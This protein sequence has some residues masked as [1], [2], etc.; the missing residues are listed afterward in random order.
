[1]YPCLHDSFECYARTCAR[2]L[3]HTHL[4]SQV[5]RRSEA[6][7]GLIDQCRLLLDTA[8]MWDGFKRSLDLRASAS[9][10]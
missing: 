9:Q 10:R 7:K 6:L 2:T 8:A 3:R 1:M 5:G 4:R